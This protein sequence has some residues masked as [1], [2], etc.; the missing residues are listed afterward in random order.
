MSGC[1]PYLRAEDTCPG[2]RQDVIGQVYC[3]PGVCPLWVLGQLLAH[4]STAMLRPDPQTGLR[5]PTLHYQPPQPHE[6]VAGCPASSRCRGG[7]APAGGEKEGAPWLLLSATH[8][9]TLGSSPSLLPLALPLIWEFSLNELFALKSVLTRP[10]W[11]N[12]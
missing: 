2:P 11:L 8:S 1:S 12:G 3:P 7:Q 5:T 9:P 6:E 10:V 4:S